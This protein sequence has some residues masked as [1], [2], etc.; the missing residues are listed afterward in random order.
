MGVSHQF[1]IIH[2][3]FSA[4]KST[5]MRIGRISIQFRGSEIWLTN[6][7]GDVKKTLVNNGIK[8]P[9]AQLVSFR[10]ISGCHHYYFVGF[11]TSERVVQVV[12]SQASALEETGLR[13]AYG[14]FRK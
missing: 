14:C 7:P 2:Q 1:H 8:P 13:C 3:N 9:F 12:F 6:L 11:S 10:R 5:K 4:T